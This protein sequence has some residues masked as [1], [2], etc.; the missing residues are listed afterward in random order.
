[1]VQRLPIALALVKAANTSENWNHCIF[2]LY[3]L[4]IK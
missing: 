1:M 2:K 3:I 4:F